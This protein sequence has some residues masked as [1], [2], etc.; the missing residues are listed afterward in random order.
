MALP[1]STETCQAHLIPQQVRPLHGSEFAYE[2]LTSFEVEK[3]RY[4]YLGDEAVSGHDCFKVEQYPEDKN[5]GYTRR[6]VWID[7]EEY[8]PRKTEFYDRKNSLLKTLT[9]HSYQQYQGKYW[10]A[11]SYAMTNH[12]SGKSTTLEWSNYRFST[13]L[14]DSDF[15]KNSIKRAR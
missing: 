3:Y 4:K 15:S 2:D 11:D 14:S 13:G 6:I 10:R 7:K 1:A 8:R 12:Q 5:S 9:F